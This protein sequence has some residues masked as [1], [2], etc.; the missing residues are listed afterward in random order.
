MS[1][2]VLL[3]AVAMVAAACAGSSTPSEATSFPEQACASTTFDHSLEDVQFAVDTFPSGEQLVICDAGGG[4]GSVVSLAADKT[5]DE[6]CS[7]DA[8]DP[9]RVVRVVTLP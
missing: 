2:R 7:I 5:A 3:L 8:L 6:A 1:A 9:G 4:K